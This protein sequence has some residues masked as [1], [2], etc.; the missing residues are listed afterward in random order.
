MIKLCQLLSNFMCPKLLIAIIFGSVSVVNWVKIGIALS[1]LSLPI[2]DT[3]SRRAIVFFSVSANAI[4]CFKKRSSFNLP[5]FFTARH[6]IFGLWC[7]NKGTNNSP[8]KPS[9][10]LPRFFNVKSRCCSSLV[11]A[12]AT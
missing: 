2:A 3:A 4:R 7:S 9:G 6:R 5:T 1:V 11:G 12:S 8:S 10:N